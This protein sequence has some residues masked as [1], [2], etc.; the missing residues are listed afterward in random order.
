MRIAGL[1]LVFVAIL[2]TLLAVAS[3]SAA[4]GLPLCPESYN[5]AT[6]TNCI[7]EV[8]SRDGNTYV[9]EWKDGKRNGQG[10]EYR[11]DGTILRSGIWEN[12]AFGSGRSEQAEATPSIMPGRLPPCRE[13][14]YAAT[15]TNCVGEYT[16]PSGNKYVGEWKD[17]KRNGQG[18]YTWPDGQRYVGEFKDGNYNGQGTYTWPGGRK[19]VGEWQDGRP[20]GQGT[21]R[22]NAR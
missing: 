20:S 3:S 1:L 8:T 9:G 12:G 19:Y 18:T 4:A 2:M 7:G 16:W 21:L 13:P 6:W 5:A 11:A 10:T 14:Y 22:R 15:W 17:G